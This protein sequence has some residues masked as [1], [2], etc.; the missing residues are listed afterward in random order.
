MNSLLTDLEQNFRKDN[1]YI[2]EFIERFYQKER[3]IEALKKLQQSQ[4]SWGGYFKRKTVAVY[5]YFIP[6]RE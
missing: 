6:R 5:R 1:K 2:Y 4:E 3:E